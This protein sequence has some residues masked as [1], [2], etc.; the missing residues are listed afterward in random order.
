MN[1]KKPINTG[2]KNIKI[3]VTDSRTETNQFDLYSY[4]I[5]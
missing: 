5:I 4:V 1:N 3:L 2:N